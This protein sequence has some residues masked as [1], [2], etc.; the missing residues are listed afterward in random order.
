MTPDTAA[1][2]APLASTERRPPAPWSWWREKRGKTTTKSADV[3]K[4]SILPVSEIP[5]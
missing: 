2:A 5:A 1:T 3:A 4:K